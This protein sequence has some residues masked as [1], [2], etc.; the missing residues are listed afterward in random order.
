MFA[1]CR[2]NPVCNTDHSGLV[3]QKSTTAP[4]FLFVFLDDGGNGGENS[5]AGGGILLA[6]WK[7]AEAALKVTAKAAA[8]ATAT[9]VAAC[10]QDTTLLQ[11]AGESP[12][13]GQYMYW[14]A[15]R[16]GGN[17][18]VGKGLST[19]NAA[20]RVEL[21]LDVMCSNQD[22]ALLLIRINGYKHFVGPEIDKGRENES[23]YYYHYHAMRDSDA[24]IWYYGG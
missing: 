14:E 21:E 13:D 10:T 5:A 7:T 8:W 15:Y 4:F 20:I 3:S 18:Y 9:A 16:I 1:Y 12:P 23:N 24:H 19:W 2:N 11:V 6:A 17:V 22:A